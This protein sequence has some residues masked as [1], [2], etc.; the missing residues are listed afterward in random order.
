MRVS[1]AADMSMY[2]PPA[3]DLRFAPSAEEIWPE[4]EE[5]RGDKDWIQ[6]EVYLES[7]KRKRTKN[8]EELV[9]RCRAINSNLQAE[10]PLWKLLVK[11]KAVHE[12]IE[13][14]KQ[15]LQDFEELGEKAIAKG[16]QEDRHHPEKQEDWHHA[17]PFAQLPEYNSIC[18]FRRENPLIDADTDVNY[19]KDSI[20]EKS[21]VHIEELNELV[22]KLSKLIGAGSKIEVPTTTTTTTTTTTK[23]RIFASDQENTSL[24]P[25]N[26]LIRP[27]PVGNIP[28]HDFFLLEMWKCMKMKVILA[29]YRT[30]E[31]LSI[32]YRNDLEPWRRSSTPLSVRPTLPLRPLPLDRSHPSPPPFL[33]AFHRRPPLACP[34]PFSAGGG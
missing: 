6:L 33:A 24:C 7:R 27:G 21:S 16:K 25:Q 34:R 22:E 11:I 15:A 20:L 4:I 1:P 9:S 18:F 28:L 14:L 5:L 19:L 10:Q 17:I 23:S 29:H 30:P 32:P 31:E 2:A 12:K 3:A 13:N 26:V 8:R